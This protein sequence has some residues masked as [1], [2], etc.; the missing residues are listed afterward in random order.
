MTQ[1]I[2]DQAKADTIASIFFDR[3]TVRV[4]PE[5]V[6]LNRL[7]DSV[8]AIES[9]Y[10]SAAEAM[11]QMCAKGFSVSDAYNAKLVLDR[12]ILQAVMDLGG[13]KF[14]AGGD[15]VRDTLWDRDLYLGIAVTNPVIDLTR[16]PAFQTANKAI[17][18]K[19]LIEDFNRPRTLPRADESMRLHA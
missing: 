12:F 5:R 3:H 19:N 2:L 1:T 18:A 10:L 15:P 9:R 17:F 8:T 13:Q 11:S 6:D 7:F 16:E 4:A 14:R